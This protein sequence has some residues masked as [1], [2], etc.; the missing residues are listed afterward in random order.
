MRVK[1]QRY[2]SAVGDL[3]FGIYVKRWWFPIWVRVD[4]WLQEDVAIKHAE[5]IKHPK[6]VEIT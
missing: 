1:V 3:R 2:I 6:P 4:Y 5:R